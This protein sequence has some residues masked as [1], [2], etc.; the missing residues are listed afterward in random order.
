MLRLILFHALL[1]G[2][3]GYAL[4]RG[5][6]DERLTAIVCIIATFASLALMGPI[7]LRYSSVEVG[8]LIVD[9]LTLSA[10]TFVALRSDRFWPMWIS[11][12]QLTAS[13]GHLLKAV[14]PDLMPLAYA[15]AGRFWGYPILIILAV[16]TWRANHRTDGSGLP[17]STTQ[18]QQA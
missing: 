1:F 5:R 2:S 11:G 3:C 17:Q 14:Q 16:G 12:L 9:V 10:F 7:Q 15:T 6:F 13:I 18:A 8:V 4:L